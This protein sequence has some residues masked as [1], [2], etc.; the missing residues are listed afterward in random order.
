MHAVA[1]GLSQHLSVGKAAPQTGVRS[2][3]ISLVS[4]KVSQKEVLEENLYL[5]AFLAS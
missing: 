1:A 2:R 4:Q 5:L 3:V